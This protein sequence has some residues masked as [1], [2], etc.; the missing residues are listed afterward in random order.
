M[1]WSLTVG[2]LV[3]MLFGSVSAAYSASFDCSVA[4]T[5]IEREICHNQGLG[6]LDE[7]LAE[8]YRD[9]IKRAPLAKRSVLRTEQ[10]QWLKQRNSCSEQSSM[11][12]HCLKNSMTERLKA[13]DERLSL[14]EQEFAKVVSSIPGNPAVAA[15]KLKDYST[16]E[17][18]AWLVY[19]N[20][21]EPTSKVSDELA[22]ARYEQALANFSD[23]SVALMASDNGYDAAATKAKAALILLRLALEDASRNE[24][25]MHCFIFKRVGW[26]AYEAF[27]GFWGSSRDSQ[28]PYCTVP[29]NLFNQPA[30]KRLWQILEV[31]MGRVSPNF[32]TIVHG[33]YASWTINELHVNIAPQD[34]M[35]IDQKFMST[36]PVEPRLSNWDEKS[37]PAIERDAVIKALPTVRQIT[38]MW[39][40]DEKGMQASAAR[41]VANNIV[42]IWMNQRL[43]LIEEFSGAE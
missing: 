11:L 35:A 28:V 39:L 13:L 27:G 9:L 2:Q 42:A 31:Q 14:Q 37:W 41:I 3:L 5:E 29:K 8:S 26:P 20:Q 40:Q 33:Y 25:Q 10:R 43:D 30:W 18:S 1:R 6:V 24:S 38:K 22:Q 23:K 4:G 32:G 7:Q 15:T 34:F 21:F 19:L 36:Q 16:A 12:V 17:A